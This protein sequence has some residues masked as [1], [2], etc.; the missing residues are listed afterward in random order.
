[1]IPIAKLQSKAGTTTSIGF[2]PGG[3]E[4]LAR[5]G[6]VDAYIVAT[7][8]GFSPLGQA[9]RFIAS[10]LGISSREIKNIADWNRF[11]NPR[12]TLVAIPAQ[13]EHA[14]FRGVILVPSETSKCYKR[15]AS[16][17]Y[18]LPHRDFY[19]NVTYE[20]IAYAS[21]VW[22]TRRLAISHLSGCNRFHESIATC[23]AEALAH[24]TDAYRNTIE[25]FTFLGCCM[26][27]HHFAGIAKLN[28]EGQTGK[29]RPI[30]I[31]EKNHESHTL[32]HLSW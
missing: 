20:A 12:V 25:S 3:L 8:E 15:F 18:G 29:H 32:V 27:E 19:Y 26:S 6:L 2:D 13:R 17:L 11:K 14:Q 30:I 21:Q 10:D 28:A 31:E 5:E 24:Y 7:E 22:S 16:P 9:T 1:M 4:P 23:N